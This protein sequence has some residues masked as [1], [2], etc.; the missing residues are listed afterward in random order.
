MTAAKYN[1]VTPPA[2]EPITLAEAKQH[3]RLDSN[4]FEGDV[5]I[6]HSIAPGS[7]DVAASY[8]LVGS[9]VD[10][11]GYLCL[12]FLSAGT[13]D[14]GGGVAAKIQDSDDGSVWRDVA[15][16]AFAV[17]TAEND[18]SI[19]EIQYTGGKRFV[20]VVATV[21]GAASDF[22]AEVLVKSGDT[23]EDALIARLITGAR[24]YCEDLTRRALA[25]Q[26]LEAY[27]EEFPSVNYIELPHP[28]L[29][30]VSSVK[31]KDCTGSETVM[32]ENADY[33]V[34]KTSEPGRIVLPYGKSW[35]SFTPYPVNPI[36]IRY[37]AG[38][39]TLPA[40]LKTAMLLHIGYFYNH[41]DAAEPD[42]ATERALRIYCTKKRAGWF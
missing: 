21:S 33:I 42:A 18:N 11:L 39:S 19:Q 34:D 36:I 16:G 17:V 32:E 24:E 30:S 3:L 40:S 1:I 20:R 13:I 27:L 4:T 2:V 15:G 7:H 12:V 38:Y 41:R 8:G 5:A 14:S 28:P 23:V 35:P 26:T 29:V 31:Y 37:E 10:V 9:A 6:Y 25:P 22:S